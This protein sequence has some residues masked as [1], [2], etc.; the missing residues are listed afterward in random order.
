MHLAYL[1]ASSG[2]LLIQA[3]IAGAAGAAVFLKLGW[4][5]ITGPFR[6]RSSASA[7]SPTRKDA[8]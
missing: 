8:A 4:A 7:E 2:S 6:K 3:L 5:R 1:D